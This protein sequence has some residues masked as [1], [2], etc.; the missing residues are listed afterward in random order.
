MDVEGESKAVDEGHN[1]V[2]SL[3]HMC[4]QQ[5]LKWQVPNPHLPRDLAQTHRYSE[6]SRHV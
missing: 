3:T 5:L 6:G 2:T 1:D 4:A